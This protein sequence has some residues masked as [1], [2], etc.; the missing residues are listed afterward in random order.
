M[1]DT[2]TTCEQSRTTSSENHGLL[3]P[4][5]SCPW[6]GGAD[7]RVE[8]R[9]L[10][11]L[12]DVQT[13]GDCGVAFL[14][15]QPDDTRLADSYPDDY[16][17]TDPGSPQVREHL[18]WKQHDFARIW[19]HIHDL[20]G[21]RLPDVGCGIGG[22]LRAVALRIAEKGMELIRQRYTWKHTAEQIA[23]IL[24]SGAPCPSTS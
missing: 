14:N 9:S 7:L 1:A 13:C 22:L 19:P 23:D 21:G 8:L 12:Y 6:C 17:Y 4:F 2:L 5:D 24:N 18:H 15:P 11:N 16:Y 3:A 20:A 10:E